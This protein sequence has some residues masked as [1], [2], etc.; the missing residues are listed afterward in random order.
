MHFL[1]LTR[2]PPG[3]RAALLT[4]ELQA[5]GLTAYNQSFAFQVPSNG[6]SRTVSGT[7]TYARF[8][9][10]RGDGREAFVLAASWKSAWDGTDDPD[11]KQVSTERA[12][13]GEGMSAYEQKRTRRSNVRGIS[14]ALVLA[15]HLSGY[16]HWS[17]DLIFVFGDGEL[18]GMQAWT[19]AYFGTEQSSEH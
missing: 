9:A 13:G 15:R 8:P 7:N 14:S 16:R 2:L 19:S 4:R 3:S 1:I 18:E 10:A 5:I 6:G 17:K 11:V 12:S